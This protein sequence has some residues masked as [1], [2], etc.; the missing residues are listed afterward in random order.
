MT[1]PILNADGTALLLP[2]GEC[3]PWDLANDRPVDWQCEA[4]RKWDAAKAEFAVAEP[5][6]YVAPPPPP[7]SFLSRELIAL[8]TPA[9]YAAI[10]AAVSGSPKLGLLWAGLLG[11]GDAPISAASER[12]Q[13]GWAGLSAALGAT[14]ADAIAAALG[15]PS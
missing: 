11:Q 15:I 9:D 6:P 4:G 12:F 10:Q 1:R 14:R 5:D 2:S 7:P 3:V 8:L 13:A